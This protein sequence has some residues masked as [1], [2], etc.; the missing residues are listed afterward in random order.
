MPSKINFISKLIIVL[1][2]AIISLGGFFLVVKPCSFISTNTEK[3]ISFFTNPLKKSCI[4]TTKPYIQFAVQTVNP[5]WST[6]LLK[7]DLIY[8]PEGVTFEAK[9][10]V[11]DNLIDSFFIKGTQSVNKETNTV[12]SE[13]AKKFEDNYPYSDLFPYTSPSLIASYKTTPGI[14]YVVT[15]LTID[16]VESELDAYLQKNNLSLE[17]LYAK[18]VKIEI[19]QEAPHYD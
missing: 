19:T 8:F 1:F 10:S 9:S 4:I 11:N 2:A 14:L 17:S 13:V 18:S 3:Q 16:K 12:E 5:F 15:D 7:Q 6:I